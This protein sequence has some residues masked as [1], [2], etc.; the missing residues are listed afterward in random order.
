MFH[1]CEHEFVSQRSKYSVEE[2]ISYIPASEPNLQD[3]A[4][5]GNIKNRVGI[6]MLYQITSYGQEHLGKG[7]D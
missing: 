4:V 7:H 1:L 5:R 6:L 2:R 3:G